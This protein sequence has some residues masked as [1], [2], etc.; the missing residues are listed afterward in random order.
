MII[1]VRKNHE[2]NNTPAFTPIII[3]K[4]INPEIA[5]K[6]EEFIE[7]YSMKKTK[8]KDQIKT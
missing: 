7:M 5:N 4:K 6:E 2:E 8:T 3:A 1:K